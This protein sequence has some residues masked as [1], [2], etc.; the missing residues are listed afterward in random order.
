MT[1]DFRFSSFPQLLDDDAV[2][3]VLRLNRIRAVHWP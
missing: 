2:E 3:F 1:A